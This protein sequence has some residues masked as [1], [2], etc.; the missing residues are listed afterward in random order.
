MLKVTSLTVKYGSIVALKNVSVHIKKGEFVA[1]I[2]SNGAGKTTL[3]NAIYG[4]A[5]FEGDVVFKDKNLSN[6]ASH[7]R[8]EMGL[9]LV[10]EGRRVFP[11]M[12]VLEN[13]ELGGFK[14]DKQFI[15]RKIDEVVELFPV[16]KERFRQLAGMLSGG[17]QQ[18][19]AIAR[20][21][22]SDPEL[23]LMD[24]PS[25]G[26]APMV[27]KEVYEKLSI[28]KK[29]GLTIF[30]VEQNAMAALKY[31]D[32]GYVLENGKIVLQGKSNELIN[33]NEIKRAY[34]GKEYKEKWER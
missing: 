13:L 22:I 3:L 25:M 24:E 16:L 31:A 18:M 26:L 12:T 28:L 17:E 8:I 27:I 21:L 1:L 9:S 19:L 33:D 20:A 5:V 4:L 14:K 23:L 7:K 11:N 15:N 10:P 34:L 32:R 30:L 6:V 2:G 29:N